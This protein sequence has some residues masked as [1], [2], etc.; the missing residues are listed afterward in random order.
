LSVKLIAG[1]G[2]PG[3]K[4][5]NTRH[6]LGY[7]A[8]DRLLENTVVKQESDTAI[9]LVYETEKYGLL[10]K[11]INYMNRSGRAL[12]ELSQAYQISPHEILVLYDDFALQLGF[13]R[14][15]AHGSSGGHNGLQS[16]IDHL[17]T[18][19]VPRVRLGI[20]T[21]EMDDWSEFVL[22]SF[23]RSE[24]SVVAEMLDLCCDAVEVILEQGITA[25]MN[26][27]NKKQ[28]LVQ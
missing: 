4:Y 28:K 16:I 7:K 26:R 11:P 6:N 19:H 23:K 10:C 22:S 15:R 3:S 9:A 14:V 12:A 2:N 1:L 5:S 27:F 18:T 17:Q 8:V 21:E 24:K 20:Q 25:A 13:I